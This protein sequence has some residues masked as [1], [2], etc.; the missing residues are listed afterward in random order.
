[1]SPQTADNHPLSP[2]SD[3]G[4]GAERHSCIRIALEKNLTIVHHRD[5]ICVVLKLEKH[6]EINV[7][8]TALSVMHWN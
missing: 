3:K 4:S 6:Y 2:V 7:F 5:I 8:N 1:M